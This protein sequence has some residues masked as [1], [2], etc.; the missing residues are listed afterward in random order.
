M[1]Q[2]LFCV[3]RLVQQ[4]TWGAGYI[5]EHKGL[6]DWDRLQITGIG[7]SYELYD[8]INVLPLE[9]YNQWMKVIELSDSRETFKGIIPRQ[10]HVTP[11]S[12]LIKQ[13]PVGI[14]GDRTVSK[15]GTNITMLNKLTQA[16]GNS[17]QIHIKPE[18]E[19]TSAWQA[20]PESWYY[21]SHGCL[22]IGTKK[23]ID[24]N[25]YQT[26]CH[27]INAY[28]HALVERVKQSKL[29]L[30]QARADARSYIAQHDPHQ[31]V[32]YVEVE[33][34]TIV[35]MSAGGVHHSW[36]QDLTRFP[37]GNILYE[38]QRNRMDD[39][40]TLRCF[41][42]GKITEHGTLR[43]ISIDDYFR[44]IDRSETA[45]DPN[46]KILKP[47]TIP[48]AGG[49]IIDELAHTSEY[50]LERICLD[51]NEA[52]SRGIALDHRYHHLYIQSGSVELTWDGRESGE[53]E[54]ILQE[55]W[56]YLI[57][58]AL[59]SYALGLT[60]GSTQAEILRSHVA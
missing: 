24:R 38:V 59:R 15:Y 41:D 31:F 45:N 52:A 35:D 34:G 17:F 53:R 51:K 25:A 21:L 7:Q 42:Q 13:D 16:L 19:S 54:V 1:I 47:R 50:V 44:F 55:G 3:P 48:F 39:I 46:L 33:P 43:D 26:I 6:A 10:I 5:L 20:K 9:Q 27:T 30:E 57:P 12:D 11:L 40:S 58:A 49:G 32:N 8:G 56:S 18:D 36:E 29:T 23:G 37:D 4:P 14:L 60:S 22:T 28:M 2:P